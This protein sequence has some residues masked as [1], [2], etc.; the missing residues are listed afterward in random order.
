MLAYHPILPTHTLVT[1]EADD[2]HGSLRKVPRFT[3]SCLQLRATGS[4]F[5]HQRAYMK[6]LKRKYASCIIMYSNVT[7]P[8][9][10]Q[11]VVKMNKSSIDRAM[12]LMISKVAA[13]GL[14]SAPYRG[15][16]HF[17][18]PK[19]LAVEAIFVAQCS[20][21]LL[22]ALGMDWSRLMRRMRTRFK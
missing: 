5:P 20:L 13:K 8:V 16:L 12:P 9:R 3:F 14:H 18:H 10:W 19:S 21:A 15:F 2:T 11:S 17:F 7:Q 1:H 4:Y 22:P 6:Y